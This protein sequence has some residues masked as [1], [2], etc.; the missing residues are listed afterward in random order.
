MLF[1]VDPASAVPVYAQIV[2]Q[3]KSAVASGILRPGDRLPSLR[4]TARAL[5]I[6]PNTVV[7][8]YRDLEAQGVVRTEQGRGSVVTT[9]ASPITAEERAERLYR[10]AEESAEQYMVEA[11]H[12]GAAPYEAAN[13][14]GR[15]LG[16]AVDRA[17]IAHPQERPASES[18]QEDTRA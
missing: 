11:Y 18:P 1:R 12:L 14:L 17:Q 4:D 5:R 10:L 9:G 7:K 6:N 13:A 3:A 2:A 16:R 8:A 15:A